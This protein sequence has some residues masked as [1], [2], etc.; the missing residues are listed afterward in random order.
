MGIPFVLK[1]RGIE[2]TKIGSL[3][4][5]RMQT[6]INQQNTFKSNILCS[7]LFIVNKITM[8]IY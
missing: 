5:H 1:F 6:A 3:N 7:D 8:F 2:Q 4:K